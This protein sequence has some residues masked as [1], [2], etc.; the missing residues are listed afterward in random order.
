[1]KINIPE[2]L[3]NHQAALVEESPLL[4][5][6][7]FLSKNPHAER[8]LQDMKEKA[9]DDLTTLISEAGMG[10]PWGPT[11]LWVGSSSGNLRD[12]DTWVTWGCSSEIVAV[13]FGALWLGFGINFIKLPVFRIE[14]ILSCKSRLG[15]RK[16]FILSAKRPT[17]R[18]PPQIFPYNSWLPQDLFKARLRTRRPSTAIW[19]ARL[20]RRHC[21]VTRFWMIAH[22]PD[23]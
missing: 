3:E 7:S 5:R 21:E 22:H 2:A 17:S 6:W 10:D 20:R 4:R 19:C 16:P 13:G 23:I 12:A 18:I 11:S 9:R 1:M 8:S 14:E 15:F